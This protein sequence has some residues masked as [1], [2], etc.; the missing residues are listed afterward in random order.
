MN[1]LKLG[2]VAD[3]IS[4]NFREAV[5]LGTA[6]GLRR[7]EVRFLQT[8]RAPVCDA[9]ELREVEQVA[10][11]ENVEV[12]A[13]S[14]G[15]FKWTNNAE[16]FRREMREVFPRAVEL[17]QRWNLPHLIVFGFHKAG[18]T[19]DSFFIAEETPPEV[20]DWFAE[21][22]EAAKAA[23][24]RLLVEP[25]PVCWLDTATRIV[26]LIE[27][28]DAR[29]IGINYDPGNV[30]WLLGRDPFDE[31]ERLAPFIENVHVK[32]FRAVE[33]A[34]P[35]WETP[36]AG[37]INFQAHFDALQKAGYAGGISLEPHLDGGKET[38]E[39]CKSA[40]ERLWRDA[41]GQNEESEKQRCILQH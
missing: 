12:T 5:S 16:D 28:I 31:F 30:A 27:R 37:V 3:E 35:V 22:G 9:A 39:I 38:I 33:G 41:W 1:N 17:A 40:V 15:L 13:L 10:S 11:G 19:E 23:D 20:F 4:R 8:G 18:A 32:N 2:I 14:P 29:N 25:E 36:G 21:A 24:L 34:K 7:Y 26:E 6:L